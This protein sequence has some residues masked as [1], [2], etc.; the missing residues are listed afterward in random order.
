MSNFSGT[1]ETVEYL[2]FLAEFS[3]CAP[4]VLDYSKWVLSVDPDHG[5]K[6]FTHSHLNGH[7]ASCDALPPQRVLSHLKETA[8][9]ECCI[10]YLESLILVRLLS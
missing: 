2:Q 10:A 7:S 3:E 1:E 9:T 5:L 8:D 4:L 6:I